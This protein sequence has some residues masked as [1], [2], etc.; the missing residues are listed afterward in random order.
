MVGN[1]TSDDL[2]V[3]QP[4]FVNLMAMK[5]LCQ[6]SVGLAHDRHRPG[7]VTLSD[8]KSFNAI[9]KSGQGAVLANPLVCNVKCHWEDE[10]LARVFNIISTAT[11]L[12][13]LADSNFVLAR[14][15]EY[16]S[17]KVERIAEAHELDEV[18]WLYLVPPAQSLAEF[19]AVEADDSY[20]V[21]KVT[22]KKKVAFGCARPVGWMML[23]SERLRDKFLCCGLRG[24]AF[25]SVKLEKGSPSGLWQLSS[26]MR[27]PPLAIQLTDG[28]GNP[29]SGDPSKACCADEGSYFPMVLRYRESELAKLPDDDLMMSAER[30]G[31][32]GY[33]MHR[34]HIVSQ[35]FRQIADKL[36][37]GQFKYG[38]VA[39]G[40]GEELQTRY[41]IPE[42]AP[43]RDVE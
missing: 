27:M 23:F 6:F 39:I 37:P 40:E 30:L 17:V 7:N 12:K 4:K 43:P 22:S 14:R 35:R 20:V 36:A 24:M 16:F 21:T 8:S 38:L 5:F 29:F 19:K 15:S 25:H 32:G 10:Q 2:E 41:T 34:S 3:Y 9:V 28:W 13:P 18:R 26:D 33:N 31:W 11:G 42:L 1:P